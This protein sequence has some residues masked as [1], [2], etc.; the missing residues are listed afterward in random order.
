VLFDRGITE[1]E[2]L[3]KEVDSQHSLERD[4]RTTELSA[5]IVWLDQGA[6]PFPRDDGVHLGKERRT[7]GR[8]R[9][10]LETRARKRHL[11]FAI[12]ELKY[13]KKA[14]LNQSIPSVVFR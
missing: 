8:A 5:G 14:L 11:L 3:L 4:R 13:S 2:P 9:K 7:F 1:V 10:P 6:Q 12:H